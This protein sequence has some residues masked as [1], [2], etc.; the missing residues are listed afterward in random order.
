MNLTNACCRP[1][2]AGTS[3]TLRF[4]TDPNAGVKTYMRILLILSILLVSA[5]DNTHIKN[6]QRFDVEGGK[7]IPYIDK[8]I[9]DD[10]WLRCE[11]IA[12]ANGNE[13]KWLPA[14]TISIKGQEETLLARVDYRPHGSMH[15]FNIE[16][17]ENEDLIYVKEFMKLNRSSNSV[18]FGAAWSS[19]GTIG[20]FAGDSS[21]Q[22]ASGSFYNPNQFHSTIAVT[23]SGVK[24][25]ISCYGKG[26]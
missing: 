26:F 6:G 11:S 23:I 9:T 13:T 5:C 3:V 1:C 15:S 10:G 2:G 17:L 12:K 7:Y 8:K 18:F 14:I 21:G 20:Y 19:D 4:T 24:G 25:E 16:A 22:E